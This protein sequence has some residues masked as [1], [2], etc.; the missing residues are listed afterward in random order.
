MPEQ[1]TYSDDEVK[2][3]IENALARSGRGAAGTSREDLLSIGEQVGI[4]ADV[5][6]LAADET[7]QAR[8][9][10]LAQ[11]SKQARRRRWLNA[12]ALVFAVANLLMFGVNYATTPGEWWVLFPVFFWGLALGVHAFVT[13]WLTRNDDERRLLNERSRVPSRMRVPA[14]DQSVEEPEQ[15]ADEERRAFRAADRR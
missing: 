9:L 1:A 8:E 5:M 12:H 2:E 4:P 13:R 15:V 11:A 7:L 14:V 3:I 6:A 10:R